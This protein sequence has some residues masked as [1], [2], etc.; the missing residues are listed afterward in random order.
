MDRLCKY[1]THLV[2]YAETEGLLD[3]VDR[4]YAINGLLA[5]FAENEYQAPSTK[6]ETPSLEEILKALCDIAAEKGLL[7]DDGVVYR[8]LF[9]TRLMGVLTPLPSWVQKE[10]SRLYAI[11]PEEATDY[12]YRL[13]LASDYIRTYRVK[14]DMKWTV[15]SSYGE[16]DITVNLSTPE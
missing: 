12:F 5:I 6:E 4:T 9:D 13:S 7:K 10:F 8:D 11:A 14:K 16:I 3:P 15:P 2:D 1:I